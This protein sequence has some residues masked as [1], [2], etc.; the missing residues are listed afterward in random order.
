MI[1]NVAPEDERLAAFM[2]R[3]EKKRDRSHV[4]CLSV[5]EWTN[6]MNASNL[7]IMQQRTR[8]KKF[9]FPSWVRRT[10]DSEAQVQE[11]EEEL[12]SAA[13]PIQAYFCVEIQA[14]KIESFQIDEWMV[15]CRKQ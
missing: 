9:M 1:D 2:N 5:E 13:N 14:G 6:A 7:G 10:A 12:L 3:V 15:L 4:R 8:K 11:V